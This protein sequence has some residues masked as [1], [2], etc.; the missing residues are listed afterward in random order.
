M[1]CLYTGL[2]GLL[3]V[4]WFGHT[5]RLAAEDMPTR[6]AELQ[7]L[8]HYV[9]QWS[10]KMQVPPTQEN[11][12]GL[13]VEGTVQARWMVDDQ[14]VLQEVDFQPAGGYR[15]MS[16]CT[17]MTYDEK[18]QKYQF[19]TFQQDGAVNRATAQWAA[20]KKTMT[21]VLEGAPNGPVVTV[22]A[23]FSQEGTEKWTMT[24]RD[25]EGKVVGKIEGVNTKRQ[26]QP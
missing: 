2:M 22:V 14:W 9:G 19:W 18:T 5:D 13:V 6:S 16:V 17:M 12:K 15:G 10:G 26:P 21:A 23:D 8:D 24:I 4:V 7:V 20:A 1:R 3:V 11:P 25:P